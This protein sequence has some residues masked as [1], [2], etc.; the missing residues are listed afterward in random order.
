MIS[1]TALYAGLAGLMFVALSLRV[2][3]KR[4]AARQSLGDGGDTELALAIRRQGNFAEYAPITLILIGLLELQGAPG[5]ALHA[6]GRVLIASRLGHGLGFR[7][8]RA[9]HLR[10]WSMVGCYGL[11]T[12]TAL[13]NLLYAVT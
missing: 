12:A 2:S 11:I 7:S 13:A 9:T 8:A 4:I 5:W 3:L 1:I 10:F 6:S